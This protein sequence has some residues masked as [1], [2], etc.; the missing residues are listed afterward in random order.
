MNS[1]QGYG[2][3]TDKY[4]AKQRQH[5]CKFSHSWN[6]LLVSLN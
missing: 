1:H 4:A 6:A 2:R 3:K 5:W